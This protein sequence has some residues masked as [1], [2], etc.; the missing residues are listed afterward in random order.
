MDEGAG[1]YPRYP[2]VV[3]VRDAPPMEGNAMPAKRQSARRTT[4]WILLTGLGLGGLLQSFPGLERHFAWARPVDP[5]VEIDQARAEF[6]RGEYRSARD[7]LL[8]IDEA[9]VGVDPRELTWLRAA[10]VL[11]QAAFEAPDSRRLTQARQELERL[12]EDPIDVWAARGFAELLRSHHVDAPHG[13]QADVLR[14]W[15]H[16]TDVDA[17]IPGYVD[18]AEAFLERGGLNGHAEVLR[19]IWTDLVAADAPRDVLEE[20]GSKLLGAPGGVAKRQYVSYGWFGDQNTARRVAEDLIARAEDRWVIAHASNVAGLLAV[21][22]GDYVAAAEHFER[23]VGLVDVADGRYARDAQHRLDEIVSPRVNVHAP[24]LLQ[25]DSAQQFQIQW[26]NLAAWSLTVRRVDVAEHLVDP[27]EFP[28]HVQATD[29]VRFG[30]GEVVWTL[31]ASDAV[32]TRARSSADAARERHVPRAERRWMDALPAGVYTVEITGET[33]DGQAA[34][35]PARAVFVVSRLG[36]LERGLREGVDGTPKR[37][38]WVVDMRDGAPLADAEL[39]VARGFHVPN[40]RTNVLRWETASH[41]PDADGRI[42]LPLDDARSEAAFLVHGTID[43]QPILFASSSYGGVPSPVDETFPGMLWTDRPL[44]RPGETVNLQA[45]RR[46]FDVR[47]RRFDVPVGDTVELR[48]RDPRGETVF[49]TTQA[50]DDNGSLDLAWDVPSDA[51]LGQHS[52]ELHDAGRK[53]WS[54]R[55]VFQ[56][57]EVRLPEFTVNV[58]L[59]TERRFVIGDTLEV[60]VDATYLFGGPVRGEAVVSVSRQVVHPI[61]PMPW[62]MPWLE[63]EA[64]RMLHGPRIWPGPSSEQVVSSE[65]LVLD[66]NGRAVL[67]LPT[68]DR[69]ES[70]PRWQYTITAEVTDAT[71]RTERGVGSVSVGRTELVAH[72]RA[73]RHVVA[74]GDRAWLTLRIE[75]AMG[76]GVAHEGR[77]RIERLDDDGR[78]PVGDERFL[79]TDDDG[80]ARFEFTPSRTGHHRVVFDGI[81]GR[82]FDFTAEVV[83]WVADP[84]TRDIVSRDDA[85]QLILDEDE[86]LGDTARVLLLCDTPGATVLL[87]R[88]HALGAEVEVI[89]LRG[90]SKLLEIPLDP[91]HRPSFTLQATRV[92]DF[93]VHHAR[94][95]VA[96]PEASR[97]LDVELSFDEAAVLPGTRAP[98]HVRVTDANGAPV[99]TILSFAVVDEALL[100]IAPRTP[101]D[102]LRAFLP[103]H[104]MSTP[105]PGSLGDRVGGYVRLAR[106]DDEEDDRYGARDD[107]DGG[108]PAPGVALEAS[109]SMADSYAPMAARALGKSS[110]LREMAVDEAAPFTP[111]NVR[112][113]FRTTALWRVGVQT[114]ADGTATIDVPLAESLTSWNALGLAIDPQTRVGTGEAT[115]R[116]RKPV[117]VRLQHP[118]VFRGEDSFVVAAVVHNETDAD[119]QAL[120]QFEAGDLTDGPQVQTVFVEAHGEARVEFRLDVPATRATPEL[121]RDDQGR[122]VGVRPGSVDVQVAV[123]SDAGED[124]LRRSVDVHPFG[125]G[126]H[127]AATRELG[128]GRTVLTF[129]PIRDRLPGSET[130]TLTVAPSMLSA[131]IDALPGLAAYPYGC[132]EQTLSR[133]V[134]A[135][136]VR[137][138]ARRVGVSTRRFDPELDA[139]VRDGLARIRELQNTGG[140]WSWWGGSDRPT[141]PYITAHVLLALAEARDAG[142]AVDRG[143]IERGRDALR[144]VMADLEGRADDMAYALMALARADQVLD[145]AARHPAALERWV[146]QLRDGRDDLT[147]YAR[148]LTAS[149]LHAY[150]MDEDAQLV[151]AHLDND[152]Q[153]NDRVDTAHWGRSHGY[154]WRGHGAVETTSFVLRAMVAIDPDHPRRDAVARWLVMNRRGN[155]WDST[156]SSAHALYALVDHLDGADELDPDYT[157]VARQGGA[158]ILR[159]AV[160]DVI[161]GGGRFALAAGVLDG[162]PI[163]LELEGRGRAYVTFE[164]DA[165]S[166]AHDVPASANIL[167]VRREVVRLEPTRTLGAGVVDVEVPME[168]GDAIA[169]GDRLRIR[170]HL[171][172]DHE[173]DFILVEDPRVAGAEPIEQLSGPFQSHGVWGHREIRDDRTAFFVDTLREGEHVIEYEVVAESPGS[174]HV[175]PARALAM[176]LPDVAG[177]STRTRVEIVAAPDG[178]VRGR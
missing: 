112:T 33:F 117:M 2:G 14:Y 73:E 130:V 155:Q 48:I 104:R 49:E 17:A 75:D 57:G 99:S 125:T 177:N 116:T 131:A 88:T 86:V 100:A 15:Q 67:R 114:A 115:I 122:I 97:L 66:E 62:R 22:R 145:G 85:V 160:D 133:F 31:R 35:E 163:E 37:E 147:P 69:G 95:V 127:V 110:A 26:R 138:V 171:R 150:A 3:A 45:I 7:R 20:L 94:A 11:R 61:W 12:L 102:P 161:D 29:W 129:D 76:R 39:T 5:V 72:L 89:R 142:V 107:A 126:L 174:F 141:H 59:D 124:A 151:L 156:R 120:V 41:R 103:A 158:E 8:A 30:Q 101:L 121:V 64:P 19:K 146:G 28:R 168:D 105:D 34:P 144:G 132:V 56:V 10:A 154:W 50:L 74:P 167:A 70:A 84:R 82:G 109:E 47:A 18:L 9:P 123:R 1:A 68:D 134:P 77:V 157:L 65:R 128:P 87:T 58:E 149:V 106:D 6:E 55:A 108:A 60:V 79:K 36:V 25:P 83:V 118:R 4:F 137:D 166:Q 164:G 27:A 54:A 44:Y 81:D 113:D 139:K 80:E 92:A 93:R 135:V 91:L 38:L 169:S 148:A 53:A 162:G 172:A 13:R 165:Y 159:V 111:A 175:A 23:A 46:R 78:T 71:R 140:G 136:A 40:T 170:L 16:R 176:Y 178:P 43:G 173:V 90:S 63:R 42:L 24:M 96:A 51:A 143:M 52:I 153:T 152:V 32:E 119:T 21:S 98:L